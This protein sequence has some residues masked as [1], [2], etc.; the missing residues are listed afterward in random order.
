MTRPAQNALRL[1][2]RHLSQLGTSGLDGARIFL[3]SSASSFRR[4]DRIVSFD[5]SLEYR[6]EFAQS[7]RTSC[8]NSSTVV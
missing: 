7:R 8:R 5:V 2:M 4:N 3:T 6:N 1:T